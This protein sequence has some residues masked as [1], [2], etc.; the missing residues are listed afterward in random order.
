M[1]TIITIILLQVGIV[2]GQTNQRVPIISHSKEVVL[3]W[4]IDNYLE[5][6]G[7]QNFDSTWL[8]SE[9]CDFIG[10]SKYSGNLIPITLKRDCKVTVMGLI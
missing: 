5:F 8:S 2:F 7:S 9:D 4:N 1:K 3:L 6:Q 10:L